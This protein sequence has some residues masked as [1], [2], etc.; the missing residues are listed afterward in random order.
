MLACLDPVCGTVSRVPVHWRQQLKCLGAVFDA[1]TGMSAMFAALHKN[2]LGDGRSSA[3]GLAIGYGHYDSLQ[4]S[5][6]VGLLPLISCQS[7]FKQAPDTFVALPC[8]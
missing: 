7:V 6:S 2:M 8:S 3:M 1:A 5:T 4:C